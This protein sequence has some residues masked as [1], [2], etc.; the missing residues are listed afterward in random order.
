MPQSLSLVLV[1]LVFSTKDRTPFLKPALRPGLHAYLA[2]VARNLECDCFLVGGI[3]D[4]IHLAIGLART[5]TI[6]KLVE[7]L[8]TASSKWFKTQSPDL[9]H[10]SWQRGYG[11]FSLGLHS[12]IR[13]TLPQAI[14]RNPGTTPPNPNLS[15]RVP[16]LPHQIRRPLRRTLPLGLI[17]PHPTHPK[18]GWPIHDGSIVMSGEH[19]RQP[20]PTPRAKEGAEKSS[21]VKGTASAVP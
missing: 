11:I 9:A 16:R 2:T 20:T 15:R 17:L 12:P 1:H 8:K 5:T 7:Q 18:S 4:H 10:F 13:P 14:H 3:E 19:H 21:F 6:A